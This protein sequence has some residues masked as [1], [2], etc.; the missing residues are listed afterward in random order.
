MTSKHEMAYTVWWHYQ[1]VI[2]AGV[3]K[4]DK[5]KK[6]VLESEEYWRN[7]WLKETEP[8]KDSVMSA[9]GFKVIDKFRGIYSII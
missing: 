3:Y 5:H 7:E 4:N 9:A 6:I 1:L 8:F 2:M